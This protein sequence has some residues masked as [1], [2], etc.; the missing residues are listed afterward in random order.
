MEAALALG[1]SDRAWELVRIIE[2]LRPGDRPPLLEAHAH[3]A[4]ARLDDDEAGFDAAE[5]DFRRL[6]MAFYLAV[7]LLE[8]GEWLAG[9]GREDEAESLLAE[10]REIFERLG[11]RPWLER[12]NSV[13]PEGRKPVPA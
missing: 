13:V 8:H 4:R 5:S 10:A 2:A 1:D 3:R 9:H 7:T 6:E 11:A 12:A